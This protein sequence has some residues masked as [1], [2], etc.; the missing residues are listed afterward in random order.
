MSDQ[1]L[2]VVYVEDDDDIRELVTMTF[3]QEA[4]IRF[5]AIGPEGP[6]L[7]QLRDAKPDLVLLDVMMPGMDGRTIAA[8]M[9]A[10][11][12]LSTVPFVFMTAKA[13]AQDAAELYELGALGIISKPFDL[14]GLPQEIRILLAKLQA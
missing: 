4:S 11:P 8:A 3:E 7:S 5:L 1:H 13:R 2:S 14:V 6:V 12:V 9:K 10:D